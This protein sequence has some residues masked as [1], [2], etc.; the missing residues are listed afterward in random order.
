M[1][2]RMELLKFIQQSGNYA[3]KGNVL[4]FQIDGRDIA[5]QAI[6]ALTLL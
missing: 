2:G 1:K 4:F 6:G 3:W 5:A